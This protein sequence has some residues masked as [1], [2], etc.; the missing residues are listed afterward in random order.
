M[1]SPAPDLVARRLLAERMGL[2]SDALS[3][4]TDEAATAL[5]AHVEQHAAKIFAVATTTQ[6]EMVLKDDVEN[7][8]K[9]VVPSASSERAKVFTDWFKRVGFVALGLAIAQVNVVRTADPLSKN[10]VWY[11]VALIAVASVCVTAGAMIDRQTMKR[12]PPP[13]LVCR[14]LSSK[15]HS[16]CRL[17]KTGRSLRCYRRLI[18]PDAHLVERTQLNAVGLTLA[19]QS[20]SSCTPGRAWLVT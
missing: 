15:R 9:Q 18:G 4:F 10:S 11:L 12:R 17:G 13:Q 19:L 1:S 14:D 8:A 7:A 16:E 20:L 6:A 5:T 2:D 3:A